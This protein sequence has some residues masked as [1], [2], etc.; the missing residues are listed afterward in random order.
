M[1]EQAQRIWKTA[2]QLYAGASRH[3]WHFAR[4]KLRHDPVFFYLLQHGLL[5][6]KGKLLDLGCG[7]GILMALLLAA[8][9][10]YLAGPWS[11]AW[12]TPPMQLELHGIELRAAKVHAAHHALQQSA[13]I[14]HGDI[15]QAEL[16]ACAVVVL[17][18]VLFYLTEQEQNQLLQ[19]IAAMLPPGGLLL[20]RE[21]DAGAGFLF[22][23]TQWIERIAGIWH[24]RLWQKL[25]Y[26]DARTWLALLEQLNFTVE[27]QTMSGGTPF[28]NILFV[29]RRD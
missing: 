18:D 13:R 24:G 15:R 11:P 20:L 3:A 6:D 21:A 12:P 25:Y 29:A 8:K 4:G 27:M 17:L 1:D 16:P 14:E 10:H 28:A 7:Q 23:V 19:R 22:F 26:R 5:P 2:T 9:Q